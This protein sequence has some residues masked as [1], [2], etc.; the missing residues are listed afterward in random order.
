MR[1]V[2]IP[3][4]V[5]AALVQILSA[6]S[7]WHVAAVV[8]VVAAAATGAIAYAVAPG[9]P[10][11]AAQKLTAAS[12]N[13]RFDAVFEALPAGMLGFGRQTGGV[14]SIAPSDG[15]AISG[16]SATVTVPANRRLRITATAEFFATSIPNGAGVSVGIV[17]AG[18]NPTW[19]GFQAVADSGNA[20]VTASQVIEKTTAGTVTYQAFL[21]S[22]AGTLGVGSIVPAT[23]SVEDLGPAP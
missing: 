4:R 19:V 7:R 2:T 3:V 9:Q 18:Q 10:F 20:T 11:Q 12:L 22:S 17:E 1:F 15:A 13:Q 14:Q 5:P 6:A 23:L 21:K 16:A 8:G